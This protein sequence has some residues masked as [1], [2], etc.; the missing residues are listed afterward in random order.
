MTRRQ[1]N[2]R[3]REKRR[4]RRYRRTEGRRRTG[5]DTQWMA[6]AACKDMNTNVFFGPITQQIKDICGGCPVKEQCVT[7]ADA[8]EINHGIWGGQARYWRLPS[9]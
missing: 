8:L 9:E 3:V 2:D 4:D 7:F 6:H 5:P 1:V